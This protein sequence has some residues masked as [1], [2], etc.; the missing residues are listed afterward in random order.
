[1]VAAWNARARLTAITR[2]EAA[3]KLHVLDSLLCLRAKIPP[4]ASVVD[5][6]SGAGFPGIPLAIVRP[7]LSM[8]LLEAVSRKAAFLEMAVAA[9]G[10]RA[11]VEPMRAEVAARDPRLREQFEV[12]VAR[13]VAPL[14]AL[15]ELVLPFV[16]VGGQAVLLKG[17]AV[18]AEAARGRVA[19]G[20]LGGAAPVLIQAALPGG[21]RRTI[22]VI[23]KTA[24][25]PQEFPRRSGVP[26]K[27]PL[28]A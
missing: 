4:R 9:L 11:R 26:V 7:D 18:R 16:R 19:A 15:C 21:V 6:G 17:P 20:I 27:H 12:A 14:P 23:R 13:A 8:V 25:T 3:A 24:A 5:V 2:P 10:L 1:L 28:G 22:V